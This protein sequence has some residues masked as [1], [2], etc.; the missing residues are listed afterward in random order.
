M[1]AMPEDRS[2]PEQP[3]TAAAPSASADADQEMMGRNALLLGEMVAIVSRLASDERVERLAIEEQ[4]PF[5]VHRNFVLFEPRRVGMNKIESAAADA[6]FDV[7]RE[8][9]RLWRQISERERVARKAAWVASRHSE[10]H[11]LRLIEADHALAVLQ[12]VA[13]REAELENLFRVERVHR[14]HNAR[15]SSQRRFIEADELDTRVTLAASYVNQ[16]QQLLRECF[17]DA[18]LAGSS[19]GSA[20]TLRQKQRAA[21]AVR[22]APR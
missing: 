17:H 20:S 13:K 11:A 5:I 16:M 14:T 9:R 8:E 19:Q 7:E 12:T 2:P 4:F 1:A 21:A 3:P 6:Y 15:I 18:M 22:E 10:R